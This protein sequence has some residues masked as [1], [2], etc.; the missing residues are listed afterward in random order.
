MHTD[1]KQINTSSLTYYY[2]K[3]H[4]DL[5]NHERSNIRKSKNIIDHNHY[6]KG[7]KYY[8]NLDKCQKA[9]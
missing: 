4:N 8:V 6:V 7:D 9:F 5:K 2:I 1:T 3:K